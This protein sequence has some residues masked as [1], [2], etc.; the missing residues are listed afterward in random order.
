MENISYH[1]WATTIVM[2][3]LCRASNSRSQTQ[4]SL[5]YSTALFVLHNG[6]AAVYLFYFGFRHLQSQA[7]Y[8]TA[9]VQWNSQ[10]TLEFDLLS[11]K[12][13]RGSSQQLW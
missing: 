1:K 10:E 7:L 4:Q 8:I 11:S 13:G 3:C 2:N 6:R 12:H 9:I 5:D